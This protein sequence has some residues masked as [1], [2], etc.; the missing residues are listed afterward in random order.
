MLE[1]RL[2]GMGWARLAHKA[3]LRLTGR[4]ARRYLQGQFTQDIDRLTSGRALYG[5]VLTPQGKAVAD[6]WVVQQGDALLLWCE[7]SLREALLARLRRFTLGHE[8]QVEVLK[9]SLIAC[10]GEPVMQ[11][12]TGGSMPSV[13]EVWRN[14]ESAM[15]V[16]PMAAGIVAGWLWGVSASSLPDAWR[17]EEAAWERVRI[18]GGLPRLTQD[19]MPGDFPLH[20]N[21][22]EMDG[23]SFDKGCYVGQEICSRMHWRGGV[24]HALYRVALS[25]AEGIEC[26]ADVSTTAVVGR[27]GSLAV[28]DAGQAWGIARLPAGSDAPTPA[29]EW[30]VKDQLLTVVAMC[31]ADR[32]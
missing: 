14:G 8:V 27:L 3:A 12:I 15:L 28:D 29:R 19:W 18:L 16:L 6:A 13:G 24:R 23:I 30:R 11:R 5:C 4:D 20:A 2:R 32:A 22:R 26:P 25:S 7:A 1:P 21:L 10:W 31:Q 9:H 17:D